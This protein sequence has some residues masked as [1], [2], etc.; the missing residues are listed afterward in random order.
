MAMNN[1]FHSG[2]TAVNGGVLMINGTNASALVTMGA[3]SG[4]TLGGVGVIGGGA[5]NAGANL[6]LLNGTAYTNGPAV[7]PGTLDYVTGDHVIGTLTVGS[8]DQTNNVTLGAYSTL[9][10]HLGA[11]V[12]CDHLA[13][14]GTLSLATAS[15][16]LQLLTPEETLSPGTYHLATFQQLGEPGQIFDAVEGLPERS[17]LVYTATGIDLV[18]VAPAPKGTVVTIQ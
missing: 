12:T 7:A 5:G 11:E 18:V 15:D 3:N 6:V 8:A 10:I 16:R 17:Q 2:G 4:A 9:V 13:V 14:N 1:S